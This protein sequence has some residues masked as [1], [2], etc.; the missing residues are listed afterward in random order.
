MTG[1][2][3]FID[4]ACEPVNPK[5][6]ATYAYIIED[7]EGNRIAADSGL[8]VEPWSD[9]ATNNVA[10][11]TALIMALKKVLELGLQHSQIEV[12]SDSQLIVNQSTGKWQ[13]NSA[14]LQPLNY[15][16][17]Q[18]LSQLGDLR[19]QWVPREQN[20]EADALTKGAYEAYI[21][22]NPR[23]A[24]DSGM[25]GSTYVFCWHCGAKIPRDSR[26]CKDCGTKLG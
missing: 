7:G 15:E 10:E 25:P 8:A 14:L 20:E 17:R 26:F 23:M 12:K 18:L 1:L 9:R 3:I 16:A 19:I 2:T 13:V 5:G 4:G 22:R 6:V 11:Y 21:Q 24:E